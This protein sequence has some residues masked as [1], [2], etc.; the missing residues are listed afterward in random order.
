MGSRK[1]HLLLFLLILLAGVFIRI[2]FLLLFSDRMDDDTSHIGLMARHILEGE[3]P[4]YNYGPGNLGSLNAFLIAPIFFVFGPTIFVL[5]G[6]FV[7]LSLFFI[8][9]TYQLAKGIYGKD[10][11]LMSFLVVSIPTVILTIYSI[12]VHVIFVLLWGSIALLVTYRVIYKYYD[13]EIKRRRS[14]FVLGLICGLSWWSYQLIVFYIMVIGL[15]LFLK[16][17]RI[18]FKMEFLIL[19]I[20]F[21]IGSL[22]FW[23]FNITFDPPFPHIFSHESKII[24]HAFLPTIYNTFTSMIPLNLGLFSLWPKDRLYKVISILLG[25]IYLLALLYIVVKKRKGILSLFRLSLNRT[26]GTEMLIVFFFLTVFIYSSTKYAHRSFFY[27]LP[28][29][30]VVPIFVGVFLSE[31]KKRSRILLTLFLSI[32]VAGNGYITY[33]SYIDFQTGGKERWFPKLDEVLDFLEAK[34]IRGTYSWLEQGRIAFES[35]EKI[36]S[37]WDLY[38]RYTEFVDSVEDIAIVV[39]KNEGFYGLSL[40]GLEENI[41][42]IGGTYEKKDLKSYVILYNFRRVERDFEEIS[43][44]GWRGE[45]SSMGSDPS[46]AFDRDIETGWSSNGPQQAG[47]SFTIDIGKTRNI[48]KVSLLA[49]RWAMDYPRGYVIE[50]SMDGLKWNSV[51]SAE[52]VLPGL[53]WFKI[54]P[55]VDRSGRVMAIFKPVKARYIRIRLTGE[56][57]KYPWSISELFIYQKPDESFK[58]VSNTHFEKGLKYE[59]EGR[60]KEAALEILETLKIGSEIEESLNRLSMYYRILKIPVNLPGKAISLAKLDLCE[61]ATDTAGKFFKRPLRNYSSSLFTVIK[62]CYE[63]KKISSEFDSFKQFIPPIKKDINFEN[64]AIFLGY[65]LSKKFVKSGDTFK[66]AYFWRCLEKIKKDYKV[67]VHFRNKDGLIVFQQDH[68]PLGG[69]YMTTEW[70][71]GEDIVEEYEIPVPKDIKP[72]IYSIFIGIYDPKNPGKRLKIKDPSFRKVIDEIAFD[73]ISVQ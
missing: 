18:F 26:D 6:Y 56:D 43:H 55:R 3:F 42:A 4:L 22:P 58:T 11:A 44:Q 23:I 12:K 16:D 36:V 24:P 28:I 63:R 33:R 13:D 69:S 7:L 66:I 25:A 34:G 59:R 37:I 30:S 53:Y 31:V 21:L 68:F 38:P 50:V 62:D 8:I 65:D 70:K 72:G 64:R 14:L 1:R 41:K 60:Y 51:S 47:I 49:G 67:F 5:R 32:L 20:S 73:E 45:S 9:I 19:I 57:P 46:L 29:L 2:A 15:F 40:E 35:K 52:I 27:L 48:N 10:T 54:Q 17:K 39:K 71:K 61:A